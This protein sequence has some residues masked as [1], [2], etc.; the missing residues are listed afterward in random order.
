MSRGPMSVL[1]QKREEINSVPWFEVLKHDGESKVENLQFFHNPYLFHIPGT[2]VNV[3]TLTTAQ[4]NV[5][6]RECP[7]HP[8]FYFYELAIHGIDSHGLVHFQRKSKRFI[9]GQPYFDREDQIIPIED[10]EKAFTPLKPIPPK[11]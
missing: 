8:G 5:S 4:A 2:T 11:R 1:E 3:I 6:L 7:D 10:F 9:D